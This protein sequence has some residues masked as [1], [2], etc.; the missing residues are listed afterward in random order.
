MRMR[1]GMRRFTRPTNAFSKE[2]GEPRDGE[3]SRPPELAGRQGAVTGRALAYLAHHPRIPSV[4]C[5]LD[6]PPNP[7][8]KRALTTLPRDSGMAPTPEERDHGHGL[9]DRNQQQH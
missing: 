3:S 6:S 4:C 9:L 1:M 2:G 5:I 8:K 7:S